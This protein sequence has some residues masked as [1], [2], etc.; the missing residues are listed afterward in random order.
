[1]TP[2]GRFLYLDWAQAD[3]LTREQAQDGSWCRIVATHDGYHRIGIRHVRS[4]RFQKGDCWL[5]EDQ[6]Q[7]VANDFAQS[8]AHIVRLQWLLPDW[9]WKVDVSSSL[10]EIQS[11]Y[12][13]VALS[14]NC[15]TAPL[16][17]QLIRAGELL[18]GDGEVSPTWGWISPTY[19]VKTA[20]LSFVVTAVAAL[21]ITLTSEWDFPQ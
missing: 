7:P 17:L 9:K 15:Q 10:I 16:N 2:A 11:P 14:V 19:S 8:A 5:I 1:M 4:V 12:G 6:I 13:W 21:P 20:G 3:L 18:Y